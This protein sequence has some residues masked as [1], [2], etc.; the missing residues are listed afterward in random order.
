MQAFS[1]YLAELSFLYGDCVTCEAQVGFDLGY[2]L[3]HCLYQQPCHG[4]GAV[5][6]IMCVVP[7]AV[8]H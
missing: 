1:H 7:L 8:G 3:A 6:I 2:L 5:Y 4:V